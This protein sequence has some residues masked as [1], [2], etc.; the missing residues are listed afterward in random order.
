MNHIKQSIKTTRGRK[1]MADKNRRKRENK[2]KI[3]TCDRQ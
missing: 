2:Q 3:I 1:R